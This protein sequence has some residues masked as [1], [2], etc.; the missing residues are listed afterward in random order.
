MH[1]SLTPEAQ[2]LAQAILR[3]NRAFSTIGLDGLDR[4]LIIAVLHDPGPWPTKTL[5]DYICFPKTSVRRRMELLQERGIVTHPEQGWVLTQKGSECAAQLLNETA[6]VVLQGQ[7]GFSPDITALT[8][9]HKARADS[10]E[11]Q[12]LHFPPLL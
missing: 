11:A 7:R 3:A 6:K 10:N 8:R 12:N 9:K 4:M 5:A 2:R 1:E